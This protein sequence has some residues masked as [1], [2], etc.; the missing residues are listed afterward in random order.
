MLRHCRNLSMSLMIICKLDIPHV[1]CRRS[2]GFV[3][4]HHTMHDGNI[5]ALD[6][7]YDDLPNLRLLVA[8]PKE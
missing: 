7:V 8:V 3:T 2:Q 6:I 4:P 1:H 5:L